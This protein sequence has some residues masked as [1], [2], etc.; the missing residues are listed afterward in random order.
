MPQT[1]AQSAAT[2]WGCV[3]VLD[4]SHA[5]R[6]PVLG[7]YPAEEAPLDVFPAGAQGRPSG[8]QMQAGL[9]G[10]MAGDGAAWARVVVCTGVSGAGDGL[11]RGG[12]RGAAVGWAARD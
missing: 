10:L 9:R 3:R 5:A 7:R 8:R 2:A 12:R 6:A 1:L 11:Q 4:A